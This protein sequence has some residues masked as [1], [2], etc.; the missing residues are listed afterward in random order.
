MKCP[1]LCIFPIAT[2]TKEREQE[3][4]CLKEECAWY[5]HGGECCTL[6]ILGSALEAISDTLADIEDK[7]PSAKD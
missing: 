6:L 2:E 7:I 5:N 1:L 3:Q 4:E